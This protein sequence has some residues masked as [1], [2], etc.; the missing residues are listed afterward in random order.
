MG[1]E[2]VYS[3]KIHPKYYRLGKSSILNGRLFSALW[4]LLA[5]CQT[6]AV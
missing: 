1:D 2:H 3:G 6:V 4:R 5:Q